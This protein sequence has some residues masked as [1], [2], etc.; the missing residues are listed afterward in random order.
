[1]TMMRPMENDEMNRASYL[2]SR[3]NLA[4]KD[5]RKASK[6]LSVKAFGSSLSPFRHSEFRRFIVLTRSRTGSNLLVSFLNSH[7]HIYAESEIFSWLA[8]RDHRDVLSKTFD[9]QPFFIKAKGF[10]LF[11]YHPQDDD[12]GALWQ[13][14]VAMKDLYVIHLKRKNILRTLVSRKIA[15]MADVWTARTSSELRTQGKRSVTFTTE[16]LREGFLQTRA[17][18]TR[19][20]EMFREH[21][22]VHVYYEDMIDSPYHTFA[23]ITDF[24]GVRYQKPGTTLK[25][26]NPESLRNLVANYDE[27][28][29]S[30][31]GTQWATFF[32]DQA[33]E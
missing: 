27:L 12:S 16:E 11:Y 3:L 2:L 18:E 31:Q 5:P 26:Q 10:K 6:F 23:Q 8:G 20:D 21:P 9:K 32:E 17:W 30:F 1:M 13:D 14:L 19:G 24:L 22:M 7:S 4:I 15:G 33:S 28:K 25:K 29:A